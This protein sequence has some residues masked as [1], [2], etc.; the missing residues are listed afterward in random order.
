M[1]FLLFMSLTAHAYTFGELV[2]ACRPIVKAQ[3]KIANPKT[4]IEKKL[5]ERM[6]TKTCIDAAKEIA[7]R[8]A[9][10]QE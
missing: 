2:M 10:G 3:V 7:D 8:I 9:A 1:S 6:A 4:D 5:L